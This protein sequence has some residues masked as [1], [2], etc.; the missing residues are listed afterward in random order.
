MQASFDFAIAAAAPGA[1]KS[2]VPVDPSL[3]LLLVEEAIHATSADHCES[4]FALLE[5]RSQTIMQPLFVPP[6]GN[7]A[8]KLALIRL[9]N[10]LLRRLSEAQDTAFRGRVLMFLS[11]VLPLSE[12]SGLNLK[13]ATN[14]DV[15]VVTESAPAGNKEKDGE[16]EAREEVGGASGGKGGGGDG[17]ADSQHQQHE[18]DWAMYGKFWGL[19]RTFANPTACIETPESWRTFAAD[20]LE[21]LDEMHRRARS[22]RGPAAAAAAE[23]PRAAAASSSSSSSSSAAAASSAPGMP[24]SSSSSSSSTWSQQDR[25]DQLAARRIARYTASP[26]LLGLQLEDPEMRLLVATQ[27]LILEQHVRNLPE[28]RRPTP[29]VE[30]AFG[31][32]APALAKRAMEL[33]DTCGEVVVAAAAAGDMH[34]GAVPGAGAGRG[35]AIAAGKRLGREVREL[36]KREAGWLQWKRA[37]SKP[38]ELPAA[39]VPRLILPGSEPP[40]DSTDGSSSADTVSI[41]RAEY[42][43]AMEATRIECG[44]GPMVPGRKRKRVL[45][46]TEGDSQA[47]ASGKGGEEPSPSME[48]GFEAY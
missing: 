9:S 7:P 24:S 1:S 31:E 41:V 38:F 22:S 39:D 6:K 16:E 14:M 47:A 12:R 43:A 18:V 45:V 27:A 8:S 13:G 37:G 33:V 10:A 19:Q 11:F 40:S 15:S 42:Q 3:P 23:A 28:A 20:A 46:E 44:D 25:E 5:G 32:T 2:T 30:A 26:S 21:V 17:D 4:L 48:G 36:L 34:G 29:A 35:S